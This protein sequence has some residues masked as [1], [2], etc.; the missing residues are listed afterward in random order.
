MK[1]CC[2]V[3]L[4]VLAGIAGTADAA[5]V[6]VSTANDIQSA[7]NN[8]AANGED[9]VIDIVAGSYPL[10]TKLTFN[11]S[12][13]KSLTLS[14]GWSVGCV[15]NSGAATTLDGQHA[16]QLLDAFN[17][18]GN[19]SVSQITFVAGTADVGSDAIVTVSTS[20]GQIWV[21]LNTFIGNR[22][23]SG[24]GALRI[25]GGSGGAV[26]VRGNLVVANR[27]ALLG[28]VYVS[29][30][31]GESYITGN[32]IVSN[33]TDAAGVAGGLTVNGGHFWIT[34]NI[35]WNNAGATGSDF[36]TLSPHSRFA[37]DI[38]L[39][40]TGY[41]GYPIEG[42]QSVD[43]QFSS[44]GGFLCFELAWYSPLVDAGVDV[45]AEGQLLGV[46]RARKPRILGAHVDIG[47]FENEVIFVD[48]FE[49]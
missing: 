28:G 39:V 17:S 27:G 1:C 33:T 45:V 10:S 21:D 35:I 47:A 32:T 4:L 5:T 25:Y 8:A 16:V 30:G 46:D 44:C 19:I 24:V 12:E 18:N 36:S 6:C 22:S 15:A 37:N 11:S 7:L 31:G 40:G 49:P 2:A 9:D 43:P 13:A 23:I 29:A 3:I 38:G 41:L 20:I 48:G 42:E 26:R 14:G 34:N